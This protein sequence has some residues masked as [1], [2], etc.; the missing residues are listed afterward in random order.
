MLILR[1]IAVLA[2]G[3]SVCLAQ[4]SQRGSIS[5]RVTD[6]SGA[7]VPDIRVTL[8]DIGRNQT[9]TTQTNDRGLYT[10]AQLSD[11]RYQV[12]VEAAGFRKSVSD[13]ISISTG[14][15]AR[16]DISLEV[17]QLTET[18]EITASVPLLQTGQA[19]IGETVARDVLNTLPVKGRNYTAFAQLAPN[20]YTTPSGGPGGGVTFMPAGGGDVGMFLNGLYTVMSWGNN[21]N[22]NIESLS[23][24]K[25]ETAGFSASNGQDIATYQAVVRPGT[26]EY[27][28][29]ML[30]HFDHSALRAWNPYTKMTVTP[31]T[32]KPLAQRTEAGGNFGGPIWFPKISRSRDRAFFF[33]DYERLFENSGGATST[34]RVPTAAERLGDFSALLQRFP[35]DQ[36]RILWNP[37][38]TTIN[39]AGQSNRTPIPNND[40]RSIG[41]N[42]EAQQILSMFPMPNGYSNPANPSD[43]RNYVI[44]RA[45]GARRYRMDSRYDL[46][47]TD[48]DNVYVAWS[49]YQT[50]SRN[51]GGLI[52]ETVGNDRRF[53]ETLSVNYARVFTPN[54]TNELIV[55]FSPSGYDPA[56][57]DVLDYYHRLDTPRNKFFK[58]LGTGMQEG[59]HR[60]ALSGNNWNSIGQSEISY[61]RQAT[62]QFSDNVQYV[63]GAHSMK[64][65]MSFLTSSQN[66]VNYIREVQ[67]SSTMTRGGSLNGR[68]GGDAVATLLLGLPTFMAQ[69]YR[70]DKEEPR[71]D[72]TFQ[73]WGFFFDNK[74]QATPKFTVS[75]GLRYDLNV[76][77]YSPGRFGNA[78]MDFSYP[79]WQL[80]IPGRAEGVP[81]HQVPVF[82]K[83]FAPRISLAY[84]VMRDFVV[85]ASYGMFYMAGA[86]ITTGQNTD[87]TI[88]SVPGYISS[89]YSN[90]GAGVHDD[91]PY[92]KWS[93]IFPTQ[94]NM[95]AG[96]YP[97]STAPGS[98][99]FDYPRDVIVYDKQSNRLPYYQRYLVEVQ[100]GFGP[101][102][103]VSA[104]YLGGRGTKL[105]YYENVNIPAYR[106][107]W[108]SESDFNDARPTTRFEDVYL[109]RNGKNSFYNSGTLKVER[110]LSKRF[111]VIAHYSFSKT[112]QDYGVPG[113][114]GVS[115]S[116]AGGFTEVPTAWD[117]N[118]RIARGESPYSHPHR[119]VAG[120][121]YELP[122]GGSLPAVAKTLLAG[123]TASGLTTFESGNAITVYNDVTSAQDFEPDMV[124]IASGNPN[125]PRGERTFQRYFR[126]ELFSAPENGVKGNAGLGI[127]R[128]PGVNN[129]DLGLAKTF[130]A[131]ERVRA[132]LRVDL[133]NAFNHTQW[134][135]VNADFSDETGNTFGWITGA[136]DGR[137][138]QFLLRVTF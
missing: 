67:F 24:V 114:F 42:S 60:I 39:A 123:W 33:V 35:G 65:G 69:P 48:N 89:E 99:W 121:S 41:I 103:M 120:W 7:V 133:N 100:K 83:N 17:G 45:G 78:R 108:E 101:N 90:A 10:F 82:K 95:V 131:T 36:N 73:N 16:I 87:Y 55:G 68:R 56:Y 122:F 77:V 26:S 38:S 1:P 44:Y 137:Y 106:T 18:V 47:L 2:L 9:D 21:Y 115:F 50:R 52:P 6:S 79:G 37:L 128:A 27:H 3:T 110:K 59:T 104:S 29:T 96:Q 125:L 4:F 70:Y 57:L 14:Q 132:E 46:R 28:G 22:P 105:R 15:A 130:R 62:K 75:L 58:N 25:V 138:T 109:T 8:T 86:S 49:R 85:R 129:W 102:T 53:Q 80:Q 23:E 84:Q 66:D 20:M 134:S 72:S 126:S 30:G 11:G 119:F 116:D 112:V 74:W 64:F 32:K 98:G 91:L 127:V 93:D 88:F 136:R 43:L 92:F 97:V 124:N 31:G 135:N 54:L 13:I 94:V 40:L 76:P 19:V 111:Q 63:K 71:N 118:G 51:I 107:G 61:N 5:G 113:G 81:T 34:Y 12:S 117:W